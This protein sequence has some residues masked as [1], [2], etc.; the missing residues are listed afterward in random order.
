LYTDT[1]RVRH[2]RCANAVHVRHD[3]CANVAFVCHDRCANIALIWKPSTGITF[4]KGKVEEIKLPVD[5]VDVIV[6]YVH[7]ALWDSQLRR[8]LRYANAVTYH[9]QWRATCSFPQSFLGLQVIFT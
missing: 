9:T 4:V 7:W 5:S 3:R 1:A 6:R 2:D 8:I